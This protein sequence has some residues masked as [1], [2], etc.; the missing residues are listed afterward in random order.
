MRGRGGE[1]EGARGE[2]EGATERG[3]E[4]HTTHSNAHTHTRTHTRTH[5]RGFP[6]SAFLLGSAR[7]ALMG[8]F[9]EKKILVLLG[10]WSYAPGC[11][12]EGFH[13]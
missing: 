10:E 1:D 9:L 4:Q 5:S 2:D 11:A 6:L 7:S 13:C 3:Q 8:A 12:E